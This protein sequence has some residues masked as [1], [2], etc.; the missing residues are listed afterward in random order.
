[1]KLPG[2]KSHVGV[3]HFIFGRSGNRCR[4]VR[5]LDALAQLLGGQGLV[6]FKQGALDTV[7]SGKTG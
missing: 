3:I 7:P 6:T 5:S 4:L 2:D 1:M